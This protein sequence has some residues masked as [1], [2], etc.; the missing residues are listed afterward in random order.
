MENSIN[1]GELDTLI[2]IQQGV[3]TTG[4]QGN[5]KYEYYEHSRVWA[6]IVRNINEMVSN[7]NLEE[8]NS[9]EVTCYKIPGL[10]V[11]WRVII[12]GIPY[13]ITAIDPISRISPLNRMTL[14]AI[15]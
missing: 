11:R 8:D 9:I 13:E 15:D 7:S 10:T 14:K 5:K 2:Q 6:K 3:L 12:D 4:S 1:I